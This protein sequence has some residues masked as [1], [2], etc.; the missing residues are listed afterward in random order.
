VPQRGA[1]SW[2]ERHW[3]WY[4]P[5]FAFSLAIGPTAV[6]ALVDAV[7][8]IPEPWRGYLYEALYFWL[9]I[10]SVSSIASLVEQE[11]TPKDHRYP[12]QSWVGT[13]LI[14]AGS[15]WLAITAQRLL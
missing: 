14:L 4:I 10:A 3:R 1:Q 2:S 11:G 12:L 6:V 15:V 13:I 8:H 7:T 9:A 5:G